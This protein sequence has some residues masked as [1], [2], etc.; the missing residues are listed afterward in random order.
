MA[1]T[2]YSTTTAGD[3]LGITRCVFDDTDWT[4]ITVPDWANTAIVAVLNSAD[5]SDTAT[6]YTAYIGVGAKTG[7]V[8]A[9]DAYTTLS[10]NRN[11]VQEFSISDK[12]K[13]VVGSDGSVTINRPQLSISVSN[14]LCHVTVTWEMR[15][16]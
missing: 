4:E 16:R 14:I 13:V 2:E 10:T 5:P 1:V 6:P 7:A 12:G 11:P 9:G 3:Q 15:R 8:G